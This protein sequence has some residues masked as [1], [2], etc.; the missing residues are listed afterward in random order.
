MFGRESALPIDF[1]FQGVER[2]AKLKNKS[3]EQFLKEWGESMEEACKIAREKMGKM[4]AYNKR[5]YDKKAKAVDIVVGDRVLMRNK[6]DRSEGTAKLTSYWEH[7]IF[8]V[9]EKRENLPVYRIKN[10]HKKS[11][12]RVVHR[13]LLMLCNELPMEVFDEETV[14]KENARKKKSNLSKKSKKP[15][16]EP[17]E[18]TGDGDGEEYEL[19]IQKTIPVTNRNIAGTEP[20]P[21]TVDEGDHE[22]IAG[23]QEHADAV[24]PVLEMVADEP[25]AAAV[26]DQEIGDVPDVIEVPDEVVQVEDSE[27]GEEESAEAVHLEES[28]FGESSDNE[29]AESEH[30]EDEE[31][32]D[33]NDETLEN[34]L[35]EEGN[36]EAESSGNYESDENLENE[37]EDDDSENGT[38][39][40][41][42]PT[43][44]V[45]TRKMFSYD[46][47]GGD[48]VFVE[49]KR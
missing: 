40:P 3:H 6:R 20:I 19:V 48:P 30:H 8:V 25:E 49:V 22:E 46:T 9:T 34:E 15:M 26:A 31:I 47:V 21:V 32:Q 41:T 28:D 7:S 38:P 29:S 4:A 10:I 24:E 17:V 33:M 45:R 1:V 14:R 42:R 13:N 16:T 36:Q 44:E 5:S 12:V 27:S 35:T 43:R 39:R 11:D 23:E 2:E 37:S 18:N